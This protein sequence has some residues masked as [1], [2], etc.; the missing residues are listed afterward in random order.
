MKSKIFQSIFLFIIIV[1][2]IGCSNTQKSHHKNG[3]VIELKD[4]ILNFGTI[5]KD[6]KLNYKLVIYN[7]GNEPLLLNKVRTTCGCT[8]ASYDKTPILPGDSGTILFNLSTDKTGGYP[9]KKI[10]I[11]SNAINNYDTAINS[12]RVICEFNWEVKEKE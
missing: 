3:A 10:A 4:S 6:R 12:S 5:Y 2:V 9:H 8:I 7:K 1:S 11:Y